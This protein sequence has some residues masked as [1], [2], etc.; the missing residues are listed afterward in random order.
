M[1]YTKIVCAFAIFLFAAS[2]NAQKPKEW[3]FIGD[4]VVNYR[5]DHDVI[6]ADD[7]IEY[8]QIRIRVTEA[9]INVMELKIYF[10]NGSVQDVSIRNPI[11]QDGE[12][13]VI[14]L[15]GGLRHLSKIEFWYSTID[16]DKGKAKVA[17]WGK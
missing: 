12:S 6:Q 4:K 10:D 17:V 16:T 7:T 11:K 2:A 15:N 13:R 8:R 9:P 5:L 3:K 1:L 14:D